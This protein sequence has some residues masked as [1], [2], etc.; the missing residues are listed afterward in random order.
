MPK[1]LAPSVGGL[2]GGGGIPNTP[3]TPDE[4]ADS[5]L[6]KA[7][8][9]GLLNKDGPLDVWEGGDDLKRFPEDLAS[10]SE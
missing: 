3:P 5:G 9:G 4:A 7:G 10:R 8:G 2:E 1:S 6:N